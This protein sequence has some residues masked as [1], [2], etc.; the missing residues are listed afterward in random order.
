MIID[1]ERKR[2]RF[3]W[4]RRKLVPT[5]EERPNKRHDF[6]R[7]IWEFIFYGPDA[8]EQSE[9]RTKTASKDD[10]M[11]AILDM[12]KEL[13]RQNA[14]L[15]SKV[16][17]IQSEF[18]VERN[19]RSREMIQNSQDKQHASTQFR[20]YSES[21]E[22]SAPEEK[23]AENKR[24]V[25]GGKRSPNPTTGIQTL[26]VLELDDIA[27]S[28]EQDVLDDKERERRENDPEL[29]E[30]KELHSKMEADEYESED[31]IFSNEVEDEKLE[32]EAGGETPAHNDE[33]RTLDNVER[34]IDDDNVILL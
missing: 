23:T 12:M 2:S 22:Q 24:K 10:K 29:K 18:T 14:I 26:G 15:Q 20:G 7:A 33:E 3:V 28:A 13:Q 31:G 8:A 27:V 21:M 32:D 6:S 9:N 19:R 11:D 34:T 25:W 17:E 4:K 30:L 5:L 16:T 1:L